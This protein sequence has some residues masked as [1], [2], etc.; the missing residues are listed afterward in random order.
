[1]KTENEGQSWQNISGDLTRDD[2]EKQKSSGG[3]ITQDNTSIEY[4][5]T[6]FTIAESPVTK[7]QIWVGSDD[8]LIHLTRDG[9]KNWVNVTPKGMPDWIRI[10]AIDPSPFEAGTAYVAATNYQ[11]DDF[12]PFL[13]KTN[14][15]GKTWKKIVNGIPDT[16]FTRAIREDPNHEGLLVAGTEFGLYISYDDG[17]NWKSFQL[18]LPITPIT[19]LMFQKG[20][21][22]LVVATQGRAF[23][24]FDDLPLLHQFDPKQVNEDLHLYQPKDAYRGRGARGS[25]G[26]GRGAAVAEGENPPAG[27]VVYYSLKDKPKG[28]LKIEFLDSE[29]K[30]VNEYSNKPADPTKA[31]PLL[32]E[33]DEDEPRPA[34]PACGD[35]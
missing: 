26:G 14:D 34:P 17:E 35:R 18:N 13:F 24:I 5:D 6:I 12:R 33:G 20:E 16:H 29:G 3:E 21:K 32:G 8:G 19:D 30:L 15:F 27:V 23:W 10:N 4:Y 2:K 22:E 7:G 25:G 9:G 1:M 28:D 11:Q 31:M